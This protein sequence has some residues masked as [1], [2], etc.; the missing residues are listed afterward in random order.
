MISMSFRVLLSTIILITYFASNGQLA[1]E[2][3]WSTLAAY[4]VNYMGVNGI[5]HGVYSPN[6]KHDIEAGLS[7]NFSDGFS[8]N[9]VFG[10]GVSY[11]YNFINAEKWKSS[12]GADY[13]RQKPLSITNIQVLSYTTRAV[14]KVTS[15]Y[16]AFIRLG[17]GVAMERSRSRGAFVQSNNITGS[18]SIGCVFRL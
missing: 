2:S 3:K 5:M 17:Y 18:L 1:N 9:P 7:Y 14:Y 15:R 16:D 13:R 10:V 4:E 11:N 8:F 6:N 12:V